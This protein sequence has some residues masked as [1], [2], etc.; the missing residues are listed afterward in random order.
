[1]GKNIIIAILSVILVILL[2][3]I[4]WNLSDLNWICTL[5]G[6]IITGL[7]TWFAVFKT[8]ELDKKA[9][10]YEN[11]YKFVHNKL[12]EFYEALDDIQEL[13]RMYFSKNREDFETIDISK[14]KNSAMRYLFKMST[15]LQLLNVSCKQEL[16][17]F[18]SII[19]NFIK[20]QKCFVEV[21]E[22]TEIIEMNKTKLRIDIN[23]FREYLCENNIDIQDRTIEI[24][25]LKID[26]LEELKLEDK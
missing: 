8:S 19:K 26:I 14:Y 22:N 9:R 7:I 11:N 12:I 1:M 24:Y 6:A 4:T 18:N 16:N 13:N 23:K 20:V 3:K 10:K 15:N 5:C 17:R 2:I 25:D 21:I